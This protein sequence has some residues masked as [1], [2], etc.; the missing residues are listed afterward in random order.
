MHK[1]IGLL[2]MCLLIAVAWLVTEVL[3]RL[4]IDPLMGL[5]YAMFPGLRTWMG[6]LFRRQAGIIDIQGRVIA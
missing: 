1:T 2:T 3:C 6:S 5:I 4:L